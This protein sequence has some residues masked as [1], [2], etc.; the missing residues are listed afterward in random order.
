MISAIQGI[1][2]AIGLLCVFALI[3]IRTAQTDKTECAEC[4]A[5][6]KITI[7][8][9]VIAIVDCKQCGGFGIGIV[10]KEEK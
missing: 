7:L 6:I 4:G 2:V 10:E 5:M 8:F 1:V 3:V 9:G